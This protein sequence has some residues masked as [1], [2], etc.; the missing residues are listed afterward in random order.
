MPFMPFDAD[1]VRRWLD[2]I[3]H[4]II[5]AEQFADGRSYDARRDDLRTI[6]AVTRCLEIVSEASRRS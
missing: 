2:D 1:A 5:L 4:H 3:H 6:Y